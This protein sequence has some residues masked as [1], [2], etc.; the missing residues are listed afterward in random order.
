MYMTKKS[1]FTTR[2]IAKSRDKVLQGFKSDP[3][4][5]KEITSI[6]DMH[7]KVNATLNGGFDTLLFKID[8]IEQ[9]QGHLTVKIDKIHDAMYDPSD[10]IIMKLS[11]I[12]VENAKQ[13]GDVEKK[14]VEMAEWK[15][16]KEKTDGI[17]TAEVDESTEKIVVLEKSVDSLVK[18]KNSTWTVVKWFL[19]ASGGGIVAL[20]FKWLEMKFTLH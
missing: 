20:F 3:P 7:Q 4:S 13:F 19:A 11:D 1:F 10:G 5:A 15:K 2:S 18:T 6:E 16:Y 17:N 9:N 8:K 12:K 14:L